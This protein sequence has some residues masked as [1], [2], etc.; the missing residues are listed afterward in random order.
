M[1]NTLE[2]MTIKQASKWASEF[3]GRNITP[4]NISYLIQY[5]RVKRT[6]SNGNI[7]IN[8]GDLVNYYESYFGKRESGWVDRI[9]DDLNWNLSFDYLK[10]AE[11]TKHVHRLHPYKGKF[12]PQLVEYYL[13]SHVDDFKKQVCFEKDD[14][15][16]DPFCGSGTTLVQANELGMHAVG[17]DISSFNVL[18]SN[19][20][21]SNYNLVDLPNEVCRITLALKQFVSDSKTVEFEQELKE[22]LVNFNNKYFPSPDFKY[23]VRSGKIKEEE[24]G[25][26]KGKEFRIIYQTLIDKYNIELKQEKIDNFL[27]KWYIKHVR[28]EIDFIH[29]LIDKIKD[30]NMRNVL[31]IMLSR[32]IRS[33]RATTHFDLATLK[34]PVFST[35][36]CHKHG[37]ICK[38]LF[39]IVS[40]WVRYSED[41]ITRLAQFDKIRTGT[42]QICLAGDSRTIDI[43]DELKKNHPALAQFVKD[44][45][46]KGIFSSPPYVGLIDYHDQHAYAYDLFHFEK[47]QHLEIGT[48]SNGQG[49][50][51]RQSYVL[52]ISE[53]LNNC[54]RFLDDD[55]D[56]FLVANDKYNLYPSIAE[57]SRLQIVERHRRPVLNRT[58][59]DKGTYSETIFHLRK[60]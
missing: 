3:L 21:I 44:K 47:K 13:D 8:Q 36:Y 22:A 15:I 24:Y 53:A 29:G 40:W 20:K 17:I 48:L 60:K 38:P 35:Y 49:I 1:V 27:D 33:C 18:I 45:K 42:N 5:G 2:L 59:R 52:A 41:T 7:L 50:E 31:T 46:I 43:V 19:I 51:A 55:F 54:V 39:S 32:T 23:K 34:K 28:R 37:K 6:A 58:E 30:A 56:I 16:L 4:S 26:E 11:R 12:I 9:G 14:I 57:K 10:E 25:A